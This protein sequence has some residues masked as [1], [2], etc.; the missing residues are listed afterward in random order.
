MLVV[1]GEDARLFGDPKEQVVVGPKDL[2]QCFIADV[3]RVVGVSEEVR[4]NVDSNMINLVGPP[5]DARGGVSRSEDGASDPVQVG[6]G[7]VGEIA[8]AVDH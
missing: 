2:E 8:G 4:D 7:A 1:R 3:G 6:L 5:I